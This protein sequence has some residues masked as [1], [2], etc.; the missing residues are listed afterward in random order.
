M[1]FSA[2]ALP[3]LPTVAEKEG[4]GKGK[5]TQDQGY[6]RGAADGGCR[7]GNFSD[8]SKKLT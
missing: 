6:H 1:I 4:G 2:P 5:V 8:I 3:L 7:A